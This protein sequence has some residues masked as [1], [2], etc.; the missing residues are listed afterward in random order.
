MTRTPSARRAAPAIALA[1]AVVGA[2]AFAAARRR[3]QDQRLLS[4]DRA[5]RTAQLARIGAST[6]TG[7]VTMKARGALA[8]EERRDELRVEFELRTAEQVAATLGGMKGALMKLGQMASYLDQG[9]PE[10]VREALALLQT[11]APPM[12]YE[13]VEQVVRDE[14]GDRP[15]QVFAR[16]DRVPIAS[17]SIGQVHRARTHDG[18]EVAVKVQYPGVDEA[19]AADLQNTDLLFQLMGMLFPGLDPAPIVEELRDRLVEELDYRNEAANQQLF[20]DAYRGHP[21]IHVPDVVHELSTGRV[22]TTEFAEGVRF[23]E[24]LEWSDEE[25]QLTAE[26]LYRFAFGGIYALHA[27]NGDPHPG[28]YVF[29]PGGRISFLDFGLCKR[30]A[31]DEVE[32]FEEM[33]R[34]IVLDRDIAAFRKIVERVGI[35]A[36][37]L[38]IPD[39]ELAEYFTHFYEI[40]MEDEVQEITPE[41]SSES[42]RRFFDL[43][44]PHAEIMKSANLPPSM[45]IIQRINLGLYALFGDLGARNNWRRIAEE[46]WPIVDAEPSTPMGRDIALWAASRA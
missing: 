6:G 38:D 26:C 33:I 11:D 36:P 22:L 32:V 14:L 17:A 10:P 35:L 2:V 25:R 29:R 12:S 46:L 23:A 30:F 4:T 31:P 1:V 3:R 37:G 44:G 18:V 15:E 28:N 45:V 21:Y 24:V 13:L 39:E 5:R 41:Y 42:V 7:Y 27:F 34:A 20:V 9:L 43:S 16:F 40:V 8:S 19:V